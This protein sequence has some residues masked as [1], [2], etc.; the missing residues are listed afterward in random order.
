MVLCLRSAWS[1]SL[2][3]KSSPALRAH[4]LCPYPVHPRP[5]E[6]C[7]CPHH[8]IKE[9][10]IYCPCPR[11]SRGSACSRLVSMLKSQLLSERGRQQAWRPRWPISGACPNSLASCSLCAGSWRSGCHSSSSQCLQ[12][13]AQTPVGT[14]Q[15]PG[16]MGQARRCL[17][18]HSFL[19]QQI[20]ALVLFS[21]VTLINVPAL[22]WECCLQ[23]KQRFMDVAMLPP[24]PNPGTPHT[25][26]SRAEHHLQAP[27][28]S[29][30]LK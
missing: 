5:Q 14:G 26:R 15:A 18:S 19:H 27:W 1:L 11:N 13:S 20:H 28:F 10:S 9:A 21:T 8:T 6:K 3:E 2:P 25:P 4:P 30:T 23:N 7:S 16:G 22:S 24:M 12:V 29:Y 17:F